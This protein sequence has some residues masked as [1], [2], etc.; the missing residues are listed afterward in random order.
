MR[1]KILDLFQKSHTVQL[2]ASSSFSDLGNMLNAHHSTQD[3]C[4]SCSYLCWVWLTDKTS[5]GLSLCQH[6]GL[7][8]ITNS[9]L[10][11]DQ[12]ALGCLSFPEL[13]L[14]VY[15]KRDIIIEN[16]RFKLTLR[17]QD[18][19]YKMTKSLCLIRFCF[20]LSPAAGLFNPAATREQQTEVMWIVVRDVLLSTLKAEILTFE[21]HYCAF[22]HCFLLNQWGS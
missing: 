20:C 3:Q 18:H 5:R 9:S 4:W 11:T 19:K 16:Q 22:Q 1:C 15:T 14:R 10:S 6:K 7:A 8:E 13:D 2:Q 12:E 21:C 17:K